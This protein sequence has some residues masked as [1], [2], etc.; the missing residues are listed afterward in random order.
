MG[1]IILKDY[2]YFLINDYDNNPCLIKVSLFHRLSIPTTCIY[3]WGQIIQFRAFEERFIPASISQI[4]D[5]LNY[6]DKN[7]TNANDHEVIWKFYDQIIKPKYKYSLERNQQINRNLWW[8]YQNNKENLFFIEKLFCNTDKVQKLNSPHKFV[9][10]NT[11]DLSNEEL[12]K[13]AETAF[14]IYLN[15]NFTGSHWRE[16]SNS[17]FRSYLEVNWNNKEN[18]SYLPYDFLINLNTE[19]YYLDVKA[20]RKTEES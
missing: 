5:Y 6:L 18:E 19:K 4:I 17:E 3:D 16:N 7:I 20:T 10:S 9:L 8:R 13:R 14:S 1:N 2:T 12:G 15:N 11:K